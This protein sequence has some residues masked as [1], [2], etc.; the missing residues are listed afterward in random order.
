MKNHQHPTPMEIDYSVVKRLRTPQEDEPQGNKKNSQC[1]KVVVETPIVEPAI[2][3]ESIRKAWPATA[4]LSAVR[5]KQEKEDKEKKEKQE[6]QE[7]EEGKRRGQEK[8][9]EEKESRMSRRWST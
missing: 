8:Q 6:Q 7:N 2:R 9:D 1:E 5:E 3:I 4:A